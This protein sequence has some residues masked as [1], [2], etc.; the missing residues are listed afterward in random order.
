MLSNLDSP[1]TIADLL[2][3]GFSA[4]VEGRHI[5]AAEHFRRAIAVLRSSEDLRWFGLGCFAASEVHDDEARLAL[6]NRWVALARDHGALSSLPLALTFL[7][8]AEVRAG[9]FRSADLIHEEGRE[10]SAA[11]GNPGMTG[12]ASP[13]DLL[14]LA[15][16][17]REAEARSTAAAVARDQAKRR[18]GVGV[19]YVDAVLTV[20]EISL[21]NYAAALGCALPVYEEDPLL[22]RNE[23]TARDRR[24]RDALRRPTGSYRG[25]RSAIRPSL[26]E[27]CTVG[28]R[29]ARSVTRPAR[30]GR[31]R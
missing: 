23:G 22:P 27:R 4:R 20:L 1:T 19:L 16:R 31:P 6:A 3:D 24:G 10:I 2:L 25:S 5:Q 7:G 9:R 12:K 8:E 14:V 15:W 17:G 28:A 26:R 18:V 29:I 21:G 13:P 30:R 11:T